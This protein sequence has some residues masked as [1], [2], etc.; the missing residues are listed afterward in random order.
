MI[1]AHSHHHPCEVIHP[2]R[3]INVSK[4][5]L[6]NPSLRNLKSPGPLPTRLCGIIICFQEEFRDNGL[7]GLEHVGQLQEGDEALPQLWS[8]AQGWERGKETRE[9]GALGSLSEANLA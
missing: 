8:K 9:D 6:V 2:L 5:P 4:F 1:F 3:A 7:H